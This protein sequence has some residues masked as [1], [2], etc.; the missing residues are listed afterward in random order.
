MS[1]LRILF[2][3]AAIVATLLTACSSGTE[4]DAVPQPPVNSGALDPADPIP[5]PTGDVIL[6]I[7]GAVSN[8]NG[9]DRILMDLDTL[10]QLPLTTVTIHEP[11]IGRDVEFTGVPVMSLMEAAGAD[12]SASSITMTA[13]DDYVIDIPMD[14]VRNESVLLATQSDGAPI[15]IEDGGPVRIIFLGESD[16]ELN[17]DNW[18]WSVARM[19]VVA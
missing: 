19:K 3:C 4:N 14:L 9:G 2:G 11:F 1:R 7:G 18:I 12:A 5:A 13:L 16:F 10:E 8:T 17:T 6:R 15:A